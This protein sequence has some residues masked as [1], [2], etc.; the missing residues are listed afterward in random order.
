MRL[1][2]KELSSWWVGLSICVGISTILQHERGELLAGEG[3]PPQLMAARAR[4]EQY[5]LNAP[6]RLPVPALPASFRAVSVPV[7]LDAPVAY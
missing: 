6:D 1:G 4:P 7:V 5:P 2:M 3:R